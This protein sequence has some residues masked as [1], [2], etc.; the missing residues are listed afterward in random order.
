M[1]LVYHTNRPDAMKMNHNTTPAAKTRHTHRGI[2]CVP[3]Q[4][5][6]LWLFCTPHF[7]KSRYLSNFSHYSAWLSSWKAVS[8]ETKEEKWGRQSGC[9]CVYWTMRQLSPFI[10][11]IDRFAVI[12]L[13]YKLVYSPLITISMLKLQACSITHNPNVA[14]G[15]ASKIQ[16]KTQKSKEEQS[17][18]QPILTG[19]LF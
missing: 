1:V 12:Q 18:G 2:F 8:W 13:I 5:V 6:W 10:C 19:Y 15:K 17:P 4:N 7:M 11:N 9:M 3:F 14:K 16:L